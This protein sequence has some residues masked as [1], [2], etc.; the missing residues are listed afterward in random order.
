MTIFKATKLK[1]S[2]RWENIQ[3]IKTWHFLYYFVKEIF[4]CLDPDLIRIR[5]KYRHTVG[6][7]AGKA[8]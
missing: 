7:C 8:K 1:K 4:A 3:H 5:T 2:P 6:Y